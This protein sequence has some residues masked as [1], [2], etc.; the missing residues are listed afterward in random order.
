MPEVSLEVQ[1]T[2]KGGLGQIADKVQAVIFLPFLFL[3]EIPPLPLQ[4]G[5]K[6]CRKN[7][8]GRKSLVC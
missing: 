3:V 4:E 6:R 1:V 7:K 2:S 5:N 8:N